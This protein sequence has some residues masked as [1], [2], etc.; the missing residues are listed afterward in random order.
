MWI[1]I[2]SNQDFIF[3]FLAF[4]THV[5]TEGKQSRIKLIVVELYAFPKQRMIDMH[6]EFLEWVQCTL[7]SNAPCN[8][9]TFLLSER[10]IR[11][12]QK[13]VSFQ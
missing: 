6:L 13:T 1:K 11:N 7:H 5:N 3:V 2:I 10:T 4:E 8:Y 12:S 9:Y